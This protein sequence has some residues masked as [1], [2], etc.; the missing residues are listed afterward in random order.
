MHAYQFISYNAETD[1]SKYKPAGDYVICFDF[2]DSI[3]DLENQGNTPAIKSAYRDYFKTIISKYTQE[4]VHPVI[5]VRVNAIGS[6]EFFSDVAMLAGIKQVHTVFLPKVNGPDD[7][8]QFEKAFKE[9]GVTYHTLIAVIE[10]RAGFDNIEQIVR[11]RPQR[12]TAVA[13]GHCDY[14][15][16]NGIFPFFHQDAR[17]YWTW[18]MHL[19]SVLKPAGVKLINSPLL[20]L[21]NEAAFRDMLNMLYAI[22]GPE[23]GQVTLTGQQTEWCNNFVYA[24]H[25]KLPQIANRLNLAVPPGYADA[26]ISAFENERKRKGFVVSAGR[27]LMSPQEYTAAQLQK[28]RE[29][30]NTIQF[31]FAGGCFPVQGTVP[32]EWLFHQVLKHRM[33]DQGKNCF[34]I[35]IVRYE[36]LENCVSKIITAAATVP[37]QVLVF[38]VRPEPVLRMTKL[39]YRYRDNHTGR[40]VHTFQVGGRKKRS[41]KMHDVLRADSRFNPVV[42]SRQHGLWKWISALNYFAGI[43]T[44]NYRHAVRTYIEQIDKLLNYCK[45]VNVQCI[46]VGPPHRTDTVAARFLS[47]W[48]EKKI[49]RKM[50]MR[51]VDFIPG[52]GFTTNDSAL[53]S[54]DG[55]YAGENYHAL[56]AEQIAAKLRPVFSEKAA[57]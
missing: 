18:I 15:L 39:Y 50:K 53:F 31:T 22:C 7:L 21:D 57:P 26:F 38:S 36:H 37:M 42:V 54:S 17:E 27:V 19:E 13:F 51:Q 48:F 33:E 44:G 8:V 11:H 46:I 20:Q 30:Q 10:T 9:A 2:E 14:N 3:Q 45:S 40:I 28:Q 23:A 35:H 25:G 34:N 29:L 24:G 6:P 52:T 16:A 5:G 12:L 47:K 32:F 41:R 49:R 43:I 1:L 4:K 56:I 55:I